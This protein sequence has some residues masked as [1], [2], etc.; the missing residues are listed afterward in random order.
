MKRILSIVLVVMLLMTGCSFIGQKNS[1][2]D[3]PIIPVAMDTTNGQDIQSN[4]AAASI[5]GSSANSGTAEASTVS[6][7][8]VS[9]NTEDLLSNVLIDNGTGKGV[10]ANTSDKNSILMTLYYRD[11]DGLLIPVTRNVIKQEGMAKAAVSGL[12]DEAV[13]REQL[14]YYGL[15]PVLPQGTKIKGMTIKNGSA[16]IDFSKEFMELA[17]KQDEEVAVTA[18]VYTLTGFKTISDVNIRVE[19]RDINT[20]SNGTD[21]SGAK[22]RNNTFINTNE[23]QLKD[24]F[25][26]C[27]L[28]Y[29]TAGNDKYNYMVPVST[30]VQKVEDSQ[31]PGVLFAE[32]SKKPGDSKVFT[33]IPEGTKL[34]SCNMENDLAVLDFS[35]QLTNYNGGNE[36]ENSLLNQIYYTMNQ[37]KG[38]AKTKILVDGKETTLPEGS[39]VAI[40]KTLPATFNNVVDK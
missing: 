20:L 25:V 24:G 21:I 15:Y 30:L 7:S 26:K 14:D 17:N 16:V 6:S 40:S 39:E 23:T 28:Y 22:S 27:D 13:T 12:V 1:N 5:T 34:L 11:K 19:G 8:A 29:M 2:D 31:L 38:I 18:V 32:L 4:A 10:T 36:K 37:L 35:A 3:E 33:S 9:D